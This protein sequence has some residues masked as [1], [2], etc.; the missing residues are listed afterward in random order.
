MRTSATWQEAASNTRA[1]CH[2]CCCPS[3]SDDIR[4]QLPQ[5]AKRFDTLDRAWLKIMADT[6]KN[7]LVLDACAAEGRLDQLRSLA[8][9]LE[10]CQASLSDYLDTKRGAFPRFYFISDDEL[11][12]ILGTSDPTSVQEHMVKLFDA[13]AGA[14]VCE[15]ARVWVCGGVQGVQAGGAGHLVSCKTCRGCVGAK[16]C[17]V[18]AAWCTAACTQPSSLRV[19]TRASW[20]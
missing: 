1:P 7:T 3:S 19:A 16:A 5:E 2:T 17:L 9:Q 4:N 14:R 8:E 13:C 12:A 20:A 6:A 11:L 10:V 15:C 18:V